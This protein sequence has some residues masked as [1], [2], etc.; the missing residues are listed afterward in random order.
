MAENLVSLAVKKKITKNTTRSLKKG[1]HNHTVELEEYWYE[2]FEFLR[3][4]SA[5][6][7]KWG[8]FTAKLH[9]FQK[10]VDRNFY[11]NVSSSSS[12]SAKDATKGAKGGRERRSW[13]ES[14]CSFKI[15]LELEQ[16]QPHY[17]RER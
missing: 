11:K 10:V 16:L 5:L 13:T 3:D 4:I 17:K 8:T 6:R 14:T 7:V 1:S 9:S 2:T 15:N 12:S